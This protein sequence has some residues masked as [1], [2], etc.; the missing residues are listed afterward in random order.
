[1]S[2]WSSSH[3][4]TVSGVTVF[5]EFLF[6]PCF[7][8]SDA[9][10]CQRV[11]GDRMDGC[12]V[13]GHTGDEFVCIHFLL[14]CRNYLNMCVSMR[15]LTHACMC[16]C[17]CTCMHACMHAHMHARTH[18]HSLSRH[19][20]VHTCTYTNLGQWM[21]RSMHPPPPPTHT[22]PKHMHACTHTYVLILM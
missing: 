16:T 20:H 13:T 8:T 2:T 9:C 4:S 7:V 18:T 14:A 1:M 5:S 3:S 10:V 11:C 19:I 15:A 21:C 22:H 17:E 6:Q 12:T